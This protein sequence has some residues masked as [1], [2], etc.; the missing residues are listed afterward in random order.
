[1]TEG[2]N[3]VGEFLIG[4][5]FI[6]DASVEELKPIGDLIQNKLHCISTHATVKAKGTDKNQTNRLASLFLFDIHG[7]LSLSL[8][9]T[10]HRLLQYS[11]HMQETNNTH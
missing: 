10:R 2:L 11:L 5:S 7:I 9:H 8:S 4:E 1:M 6:D 3:S